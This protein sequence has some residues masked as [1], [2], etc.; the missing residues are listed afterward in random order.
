MPAGADKLALLE[1]AQARLGAAGYRAIGMD[2]FALPDDELARAQAERRLWR[3][4][5]GYTTRR[6]H[7]RVAVGASGISDF[8]DALRRTITRS[9]N[10]RRR[11]RQGGTSRA[12]WRRWPRS[13]AM[14][15]W[16]RAGARSR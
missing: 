6:A 12:S 5:Q 14:A 8:G 7:A 2:H 1:I 4:F 15:C 16:P 10:T 13:S 11:S 3:D 9:A